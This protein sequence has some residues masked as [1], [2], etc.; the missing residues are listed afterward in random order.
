MQKLTVIK[1]CEC[2]AASDATSTVFKVFHFQPLS[3]FLNS[4]TALICINPYADYA[5]NSSVY[6]PESKEAIFNS[7]EKHTLRED[8]QWRLYI[9]RAALIH[10]QYAEEAYAKVVDNR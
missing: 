8:F 1:S 9:T 3:E 4:T 7:L 5:A 10:A 2:T 6:Q